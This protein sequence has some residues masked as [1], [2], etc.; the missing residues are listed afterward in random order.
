MTQFAQ[1][2]FKLLWSLHEDPRVF[3]EYV[4]EHVEVPIQLGRDVSAVV[5]L[6]AD[7]SEAVVA[8][9]EGALDG[10]LNLLD[11]FLEFFRTFFV[12]VCRHG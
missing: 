7:V 4:V 6:L 1:E 9:L 3:F 10:T 11:F 12:E 2:L 8:A 5:G